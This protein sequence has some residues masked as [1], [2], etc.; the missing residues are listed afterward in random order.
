MNRRIQDVLNNR[1]ENYLLPFF[2]QHG[3]DEAVLR[4]E[5]AKIAESG[6]GAVC[7]ESRPHPEFCGPKWWRDMDIIMDESRRRGMKVWILDDAHFPTGYANGWIRDKH[8]ELQKVYLAER[9]VDVVGPQP[10]AWV[11]AGAWLGA[12]E[13]LV[14]AVAVPRTAEGQ[15]TGGAAVDVTARVV[16]GRLHWDIPEGWWR[17]FLV[18]ETRSGGGN[19]D[20]LNPIDPASCR[21]LIDAVYEPHFARYGADFG[22]TLAGFFSDE[23]NIG[24]GGGLYDAIIGRRLMALP[25]RAGLLDELAREFGGPV[26][27]LLPGLWHDIGPGSWPIRLAYMNLVSRLYGQCFTNQIGAWCLEHNVE[28]IGH[29]IEDNDAHTRL[30]HSVPH[31]FRAL[32]GQTMSGI[33]VVLWQVRPGFDRQPFAWP[34][35]EADGEFFHYELAKL[36]ASLSHITPHQR[37][38]AMCEIYGA[39]GWAEGL[40][41]MKWLTD[42]MLVRGINYYVPHAFSPKEFPDGD[43][44]PHFYA[45]GRNPQFRQMRP[46]M[47][48][49]NRLCH[50]LS[51]GRHVAEA[52]LLYQA[53]AEW[54]GECMS[55]KA[56]LRVLMQS[57]LDADVIPFDTLAGACVR[58]G[59]LHVAAEDYGCLILPWAQRWPRAILEC[60]LRLLE[61]G[62]PVA[63][64]NDWPTE[65]TDGPCGALEAIRKHPR[66]RVAPLES[67]P[68][69][70]NEWGLR[71]PRTATREP[72][73]RRY[74][75]RHEGLA[76][77]MFFNE[78][79]FRTV[80]TSVHLDTSARLLAYDPFANT[81][82]AMPAVR[83]GAGQRVGLVL[84]PDE[85][86]VLLAGD[87]PEA[88]PRVHWSQAQRAL[89]LK[90]GPWQ[91]ALADAQAYP[92]FTPWRTLDNL[93]NLC[94]P[95]LL[96]EFTGT[97]AYETAFSADKPA[98]RAW[99]DL[100]EVGEVAQVWLNDKPLGL[101]MHRPYVFDA[102]EAL[103]GGPNRLRVE[104]TNTLGFAMSDWLS[105]FGQQDASGLVGPVRLL[106]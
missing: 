101:R 49:T 21:V 66:A 3:E 10:G 1:G 9:H 8:P 97:I 71:G 56:P 103:K 77:W 40:R 84:S 47:E 98:G 29:I 105:R 92:V 16:D 79:P 55:A 60:V 30:G 78:E 93:A 90:T 39:Y 59:K 50:L 12:D 36:G 68:G 33:D 44:P 26:V 13:K 45:R 81:L 69:V 28:Y 46:L 58:E 102:G 4:E 82:A 20:Y 52:A 15:P 54:S 64:V 87:L 88:P 22:G 94:Q 104:V 27:T 99:L 80:R 11:R 85:S 6:I 32:A 73:L 51:G 65:G 17:V 70:L 23:P 106:V 72:G 41:L 31:F 5:M 62:L 14:A 48:Y 2:W 86:V 76:V 61:A 42:H 63:F 96:P 67:L 37:G 53:E 100:G 95:G 34:V 74:E 25:W 19:Q 24:N 38:R 89:P 57:Q 91:V 35:G 18:V 75:Y 43:C 83:D 7:V